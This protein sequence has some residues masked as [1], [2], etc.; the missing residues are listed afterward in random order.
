V[1]KIKERVEFCLAQAE[2][3][4]DNSHIWEHLA[5]LWKEALAQWETV[6]ELEQRVKGLS[7]KT[8]EQGDGQHHHSERREGEEK[9]T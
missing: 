3:N 9:E 6:L 4:P 1:D 8:K 7:E 2:L 5:S